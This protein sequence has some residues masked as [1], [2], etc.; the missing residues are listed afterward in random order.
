MKII[1]M[2][3]GIFD[4]TQADLEGKPCLVLLADS[5]EELSAAMQSISWGDA[6]TVVRA[7]EPNGDAP[8]DGET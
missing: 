5:R 8:K 1:S 7:G 6:V 4:D 2:G 3:D